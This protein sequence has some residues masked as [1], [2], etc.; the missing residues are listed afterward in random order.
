MS[1]P[2]FCCVVAV[3]VS[4]YLCCCC[5]RCIAVDSYFVVVV[6]I[7]LWLLGC[8]SC[9]LLSCCFC[10]SCC[11]WFGFVIHCCRDVVACVM[12]LL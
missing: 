7:L 9:V 5:T 6:M 11:V 8:Y 1:L 2:W 3:S 4:L 10:L 12:F